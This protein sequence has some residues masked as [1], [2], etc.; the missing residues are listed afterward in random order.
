MLLHTRGPS[1][2]DGTRSIVNSTIHLSAAITRT[3]LKRLWEI[4]TLRYN[5]QSNV[6]HI[7][8]LVPGTVAIKIIVTAK[9]ATLTVCKKLMTM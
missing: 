9:Y 8:Y 4:S 6:K 2:V 3:Y 7:R 5:L 1:R